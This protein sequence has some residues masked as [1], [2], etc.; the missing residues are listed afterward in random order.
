MDDAAFI[1]KYRRLCGHI[2]WDFVRRSHRG[3]SDV[4]LSQE[5]AEDF[6][7]CA[8]LKL[9]RCPAEHRE[10]KWYVQRVIENAITTAW[11]KRLKQLELEKEATPK[12]LRVS[13]GTTSASSDRFGMLASSDI[14][15]LL[16]GPDGLAGKT[17]VKFDYAAISALM[18]KLPESQRL[19]LELSFG[20]DGCQP[21]SPER[22]AKKLGRSSLWV[23]LKYEAG[24]KR[25]REEI[26]CPRPFLAV[27]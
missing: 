27:S 11:R 7:S 12:V 16:P 3:I 23:R 5:D 17:Q 13:T 2:A 6:A 15:D 10:N 14:F 8:L 24:V 26:S 1:E 4:V 25:L 19:V 20:L 22:I 18:P 9:V 21:C